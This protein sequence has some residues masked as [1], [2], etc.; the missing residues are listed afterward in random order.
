MEDG[1]FI[2]ALDSTLGTM[3]VH[4]KV[5]NGTVGRLR[6]IMPTNA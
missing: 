6:T 5:Y 4:K 2:R 1:P 3:N